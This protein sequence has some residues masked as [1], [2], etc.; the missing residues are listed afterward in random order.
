MAR[1][2]FDDDLPPSRPANP[3]DDEAEDRA[4]ATPAEAAAAIEHAAA[5][6]RR[7]KG[8]VGAEGMTLSATRELMDQLNAAL[9]AMAR[10][11]RGLDGS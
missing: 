3:F 4:T 5:R 11:L 9:R 10:G 2:P 1:N 8:Q 6:I 7:L